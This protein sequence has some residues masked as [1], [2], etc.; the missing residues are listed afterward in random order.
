MAA[1]VSKFDKLLCARIV[2]RQL[3]LVLQ[4]KLVMLMRESPFL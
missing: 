1:L 4:E 2:P 3:V